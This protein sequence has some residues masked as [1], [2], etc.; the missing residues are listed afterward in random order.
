MAR[1]LFGTVSGMPLY[2][3]FQSGARLPASAAAV[4]RAALLGA[5]WDAAVLASIVLL[6]WA[7]HTWIEVPARRRWGRR[8]AA[9]GAAAQGA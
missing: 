5:A 8:V 7:A 2:R 4:G 6:S 9:R 1:M 3:R